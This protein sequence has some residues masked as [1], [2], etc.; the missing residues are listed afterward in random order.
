MMLD[1]EALRILAEERAQTQ[2]AL[3]YPP[4]NERKEAFRILADRYYREYITPPKMVRA[5]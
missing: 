1:Y 4:G 2:A 5:G 3:M